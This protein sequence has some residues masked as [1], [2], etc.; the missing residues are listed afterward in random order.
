MVLL[1]VGFLPTAVSTDWANSFIR[2]TASETLGRPVTLENVAWTWS[3]GIHIKN[4]VIPDLP[5]FSDRPLAALEY[6][7]IKPDISALLRRRINIELRVSGLMVTIIKTPDGTLNLAALAETGSK[8]ETSA[9]PPETEKIEKPES[10][11]EKSNDA[12]PAKG[13]TPAGLPAALKDISAS[14]R[15]AGIN[16]LYDDQGKNETYQVADLNL[17]V[18]A[19]SVKTKPVLLKLGADIRANGTMIP[20]STLSVTAD[21]LFDKDGVLTLNRVTG[22]FN[23][24]LPGILAK[25]DADLAQATAAGQIHMDLAEIFS[26][27]APLIPDFPSPTAIS[28]KI[29]FSAE[30][31]TDPD[32]PLAFDAALA[33]ADLSVSGRVINGKSV[34]PGNVNVHLNGILDLPAE[35]LELKTAH[36]KLL[37]NSVIQASGRVSQFQQDSKKINLAASPFYLDMDELISFAAPFIP[38]ILIVKKA[39]GKSAFISL[40]QLRFD[41]FLP[42]GDADIGLEGLNIHL[43]DIGLLDAAN[44]NPMLTVAGGRANFEQLKSHLVDLF[45]TS[46]GLSLSLSVDRLISGKGKDA[47]SI[48]GIRLKGLNAGVQNFTRAPDTLTGYSGEVSLD[49]QLTMDMLTLPDLV[50]VAGISQSLKLNTDISS[51]NTISSVL[52]HLDVSAQKISVLKPDIGPLETSA[53]IHL[54][55]RNLFIKKIDPLRLDVEKF[56]ARVN[57]EDALA[58][59]IIANAVDTAN[60]S[61]D[62]ELLLNADMGAISGKL[63]DRI[64]AGLAGSGDATLSIRA[65]GRQPNEKETNGLKKKELPGNLEFIDTLHLALTLENSRIEIPQNQAAPIR[66]GDFSG[67]PVIEYTLEGNTGNGKLNCDI[68]AGSVTGLPGIASGAPMNA[69]LTM[70]A[71]HE[72]AS[73]I[74]LSQSF[75]VEPA[76]VRQTFAAAVD[77]LDKIVARTPFPGLPGLISKLAAD[78]SAGVTIPDLRMLKQAG[79]PGFADIDLD[80][81]LAGG[82]IFQLRPDQF[83]AGNLTLTAEALNINVA[84][85]IALENINA[86]L[87]FTK[88]Y[89]IQ[90]MERQSPEPQNTGLSSNVFD[91]PA[92]SLSSFQNNEIY[93]H[94]RY[95][96]ER[97][98]PDPAVSFE[99]A[100]VKA[101]PF[102]LII[103]ESM[104][105]LNLQDGLPNLDYFQFNLLGGTINGAIALVEKQKSFGANTA[106]TFSGINFAEIFPR[107][108]AREDY[109]KADISGALYAD[110][111]V[112][113][114]LDNLLEN[115]DITITFTRIGSRA[116]ER[117]L[118]ALDPYESNEAIVTQRRFLKN[119][120]P[121]NI[122]LEIRDGF[123][124]LTGKVTIRGI[125]ISLPAIRRLNIAKIPGLDKFEQS[126]SG[127]AP[128]VEILHKASARGIVIDKNAETFSFEQ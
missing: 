59:S 67:Q 23:A 4:L 54:A 114:Q 106:L 117:L 96:H 77:H 84:K 65:A 102:P 94:I 35:T 74:D 78:I 88:S 64:L 83:V 42:K 26:V 92:Q 128:A 39:A 110:F 119:G 48:S 52:D 34:G 87:D 25:L 62:A 31:G 33:C 19:P 103:E 1:V 30:A 14:I 24:D 37:E 18:E 100:D 70:T 116:M 89:A 73:S 55:C 41:G 86:N 27:A 9:P 125:D 122:T 127:I 82:A 93:R 3:D 120:S 61:F 28:G 60:T 97:M 57:A 17:D 10:D 98:N 36:V 99:K 112:T 104:I 101:A 90:S 16:L 53:A 115:A 113:D 20:R 91:S 76:G 118:Y 63:P 123:L 5:A 69:T 22:K 40:S 49:N 51:K 45:P 21:H 50:N 13:K 68:T 105:I 124:T 81:A 72:Y 58:L 121:K 71:A 107:A 43:P 126:L 111:P 95:L 6:A 32:H 11:Q 85:T 7:K 80:G 75:S 108:F 44:G 29:T 38:E 109:S 47:I 15:L 12:V 66:V 8:K 79:I 46:A 2:D 56:I